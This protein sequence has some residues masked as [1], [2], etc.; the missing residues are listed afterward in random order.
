MCAE[1]CKRCRYSR[2]ADEEET[3]VWGDLGVTTHYFI[4]DF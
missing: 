3:N 4:G 2:C 1:L